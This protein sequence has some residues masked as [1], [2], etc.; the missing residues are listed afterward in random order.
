MAD[1]CFSEP[2]VVISQPKFGLRQ[3]FDL[4][5][6][7]TLSFTKPE[8]VWATAAAILKLYMMSLLRCRW[9]NLDKILEL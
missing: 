3:D 1:V 6:R 4:R 5:I 9:P 2:E 7:V 8:V